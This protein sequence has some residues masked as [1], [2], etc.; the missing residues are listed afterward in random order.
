MLGIILI[1]F[2]GKKFHEL[3]EEFDKKKWLYAITGVIAYYIGTFLCGIILGLCDLLLG[4][5]LVEILE[6][7]LIA[8][9]IGLPFGILACYLY[10]LIVEKKFKKEAA[11]QDTLEDIGK[12][13]Q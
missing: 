13:I 11:T 6:N 2:I 3:A 10:Y 5:N 12:T 1:Y 4:T 8:S 9:L 7:N